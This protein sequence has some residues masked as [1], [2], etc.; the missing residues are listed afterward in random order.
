MTD[1]P[2]VDQQR[3]HVGSAGWDATNERGP[4]VR[5]PST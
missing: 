1:R 3:G 4:T 2:T 5:P